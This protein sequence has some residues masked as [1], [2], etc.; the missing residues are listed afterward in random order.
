RVATR[1]PVAQRGRPPDGRRGVAT[2]D[3]C[4]SMRAQRAAAY[5]KVGLKRGFAL[6][7]HWDNKVQ[8]ACR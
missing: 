3:S 7:S 2:D 4:E 6:S 8:Q 1:P 5:E